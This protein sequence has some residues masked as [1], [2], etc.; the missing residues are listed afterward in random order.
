MSAN[1]PLS[2]EKSSFPL[3]SR[4]S[5]LWLALGFVGLAFSNGM[6]II[7]V[8]T[9]LAPVFMV[10]FLRTQKAFPG[11]FLGY[12]ASAVAFYF[13]WQAAFQDAGAMF[14]LYTGIFGLLVFL[15]Y[16]VDRLLRP[17]VRGFA[18]TLILPTAWVTMEF[19]LHLILPLGT[20]FSV[21]YTQSIDLPLLQI[22]SITGLWGVTFLVVWFASVINYA[23]E[24][25]FGG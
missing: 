5:F 18:A 1:S 22:M 13:E 19:L 12:V 23:W 14:T 9:W 15:P 11:L 20:F 21:A 7:P 2:L 8:A 10:R 16:V 6:H 17:A 4:W 25:G 24:G 3:H